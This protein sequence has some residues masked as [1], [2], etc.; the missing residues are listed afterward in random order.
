MLLHDIHWDWMYL[1]NFD[2]SKLL[3][4][5]T[6]N[7]QP[8]IRSLLSK[9]QFADV[10]KEELGLLKGIEATVNVDPSAVAKFHRHRPVPFALKKKVEKALQTQVA[11][12]KLIAVEQSE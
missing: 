12:G 3:R 9:S 5:A 4:K 1:L 10:F 6:H 2:V 7:H 11:E 8:L